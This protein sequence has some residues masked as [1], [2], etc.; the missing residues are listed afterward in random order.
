VPY[1]DALAAKHPHVVDYFL[2]GGRE[3]VAQ[4]AAALHA[5][6]DLTAPLIAAEVATRVG[7]LAAELNKEDPHYRYDI[8]I[9]GEPVE[10]LNAAGGT[11][12]LQS[13][14]LDNGTYVSVAVVQKHRYS[15]I[16]SPIGGTLTIRLQD[17]DDELREKVNAFWEFGRPLELPPGT[18]D[19][20][21]NAPG[22]LGGAFTGGGGFFGPAPSP[23]MTPQQWRAV[24]VS[25][26][27]DVVAELHLQV[28]RPTLGQLGGAEFEL[29]DSH[30][31][32]DATLSVPSG[33]AEP[34]RINFA[35]KM[36]DL[37]GRPVEEVLPVARL[38]SSL[39]EPNE[40]Q[41]RPRYGTKVIVRAPCEGDAAFDR[42]LLLHIEDL[43]FVQQRAP[44][45]VCVPDELDP[46]FATELHDHVRMLQ[47][48]AITGTWDQLTAHLNAPRPA[49][50]KLLE[51]G[52]VLA[53]ARNTSI[54][55]DGQ[56]IDLGVFTTFLHSVSLAPD[57]PD[58][59]MQAKLVPGADNRFTRRAGAPPGK[60][61]EGG[62]DSPHR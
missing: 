23:E 2:A 14:R 44:G 24:V 39:H 35:F 57:Q 4:R 21:L 33:G 26:D 13:E 32:F 34:K 53:I 10:P 12:L 27:D 7:A 15:L 54:E 55:V 60:L 47:G 5:A 19:V 40:I 17:G 46:G 51:H 52:G 48:E 42:G 37:A 29:H 41:L 62:L 8:T 18:L 20:T 49:T 3:R 28:S 31:L 16:D 38:L 9:T 58:D 22:G 6:L 61:E 1:W 45:T 25:P 50:T 30:G 43:A 11:V 59:P 56:E 36:H